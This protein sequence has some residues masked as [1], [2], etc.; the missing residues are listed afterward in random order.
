MG[1]PNIVRG[2]SQSG[3]ISARELV[4]QDCCDF[5]CSDYHHS[6]MLQAVYALH[7]EMGIELARAFTYITSTPARIARL[8]DR[9]EIGPH[10]LADLAIIDDLLVPKVVLTMKSGNPIYSGSSCFCI[11]ETA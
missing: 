5:L 10:K 7:L 3:N 9:G 4:Q 8:T 2:R 11:H 1:A 6:S